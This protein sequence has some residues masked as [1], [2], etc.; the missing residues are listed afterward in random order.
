[1]YNGNRITLIAPMDAFTPDPPAWT[2]TATHAHTFACPQCGA[3]EKEAQSVWPQFLPKNVAVSGKNFINVVAAKFGGAGATIDHP[4]SLPIAK[5]RAMTIR[6]FFW[7]I[8][9]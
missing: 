6:I 3:S 2:E 9:R 4:M 1:M 7:D 5:S 8:F